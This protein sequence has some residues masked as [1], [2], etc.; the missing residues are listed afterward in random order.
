MSSDHSAGH[1]PA[2]SDG[3]L[4]EHAANA[5]DESMIVSEGDEAGFVDRRV[6]LAICM[7]ALLVG[8]FLI[9]ASYQIRRGSIPDPIGSGGW[10]RL[11][12]A[13]LTIVAGTLVLRR[14]VSWRATL[15]HL[16]PSD[17]GKEGEAGYPSSGL[18]PFII[19][20]AGFGWILA[21]PRVGFLIATF[22]ATVVVVV[23]MHVRGLVKLMVVPF[24]FTFSI[25]LLFGQVFG[26]H[27]PSRFLEKAL[28]GIIP[29]LQ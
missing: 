15:D 21:L 3:T 19:L 8:L 29:G 25:W 9:Y 12:G 13:A 6:D 22:A 1:T 27:F 4:V 7:F 20:A 17:G 16:V 5:S 26:I 23:A 24:L 28:Q 10:Q 2:T 11:I 14:L 18:R